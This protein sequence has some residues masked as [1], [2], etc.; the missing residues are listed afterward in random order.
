MPIIGITSDIAASGQKQLLKLNKEYA[1]AVERAGG[2]PV[3]LSPSKNI[4]TLAE[5]IDALLIPGGGDL[6]PSYYKETNDFPLNIVSK[7]RSDFEISLFHEIIKLR[8]PIL[9]ICYGMQLINVATGGSLYQDINSQ[10][11]DSLEHKDQG[12][13]VE[14]SKNKF[15]KEGKYTVNSFHHQAV[16]ML[17][18][19]LKAIAVSDDNIIEAI[20]SEKYPFLLGVQWHPE[21]MNDILSEAIF[22][23]FVSKA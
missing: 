7:E 11:D 23:T 14:I 22:K 19:K 16:K 9:G 10:V 12:H 1:D 13:S 3:I 5:L 21:R 2:C 18:D 8:K 4:K 15:F 17:G 6:E 20:C